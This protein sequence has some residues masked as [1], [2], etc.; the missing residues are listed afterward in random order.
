[1]GDPETLARLVERQP[2][3]E[4]EGW[5]A[6]YPDADGGDGLADSGDVAS[7]HPMPFGEANVGLWGE[8]VKYFDL[9]EVIALLQHLA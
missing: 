5:I 3:P 1:M 7:D 4:A 9:I 6:G 8:M 2:I